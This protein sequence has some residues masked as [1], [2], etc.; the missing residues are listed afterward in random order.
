MTVRVKLNGHIRSIDK[1]I[2][3]VVTELNKR[4]FKT[5]FSC[6]SLNEDHPKQTPRDRSDAP[7][8][9]VEG[10]RPELIDIAEAAGWEWQF[11]GYAYAKNESPIDRIDFRGKPDGQILKVKSRAL[12]RPEEDSEGYPIL[13]ELES[14]MLSSKEEAIQSKTQSTELILDSETEKFKKQKIACLLKVIT[15]Q[16]A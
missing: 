1:G 10:K 5:L 16:S 11:S 14:E 3:D 13:W 4:G 8:V 6:S 7:Y 9:T 2:L 12:E 15:Q